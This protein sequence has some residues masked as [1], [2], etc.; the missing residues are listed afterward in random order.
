MIETENN[1]NIFA[2]VSDLLSNE[3]PVLE[4]SLRLTAID[5]E[6]ILPLEQSVTE[7][8]LEQPVLRSIF[9][10][11]E[12]ECKFLMDGELNTFFPEQ[13]NVRS[14]VAIPLRANQNFG[15]LLLASTNE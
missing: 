10:D 11:N 13:L 7:E 15:V 12:R 9:L 14:G 3:F 2:V 4:V 1:N 8:E 6:W 5:D